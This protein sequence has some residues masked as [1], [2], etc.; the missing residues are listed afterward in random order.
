MLSACH[1]GDELGVI[2]PDLVRFFYFVLVLDLVCC[3]YFEL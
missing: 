2:V 1:N 3:L